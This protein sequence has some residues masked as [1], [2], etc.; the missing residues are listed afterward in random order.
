MKNIDLVI[1]A[2]GKGTRIKE[3][4]DNKPKPMAKFNNIYFLQYLLNSYGKYSF[5]KIFIL[6]GYK[7][8]IIYRN[9]HNKI[10]NLTKIKC[11][12]E[13][14][15]MGTGGALLNLKK[16]KINNFVLINGDTIFDIDVNNLVKICGN[17]NLGSIALAEN[18]KNINNF[19]LNNL[20]LKKNKLSYRRK[21][22]LMNGGIYFFKKKIL[23]MLPRKK[24]SLEDDFLP[25][26]INRKLLKGKVYNNFF[27]DIGT[28]KY[29]KISEKKL[30]NYF[31]KPAIFLDRD[32]V[33][34][35]DLG[36]VYK[37]KDFRFKKGVI[38]GLKYISKKKYLIFIVTNQAG[39]AK[40][41]YKEKDFFK[42]QSHLS[43]KL[44][45]YNIIIND[46]QYSPFHPKASI[47]K[48]RKNSNLRKPGNQM[49]KNIM[50]N[51]IIDKK[52][53]FMIGDKISDKVCANKSNIKF[54][55]A[56]NNFE[57]L[58]KKIV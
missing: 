54:Y 13:K 24:F 44:L 14:K 21:G 39:I 2:G 33:I 18:R 12:K 25:N 10:F 17:K 36:Y 43:K 38:K 53:S 49:I 29:F 6:T 7:H 52:K 56:E 40:G 1:L 5:N 4:L 34:N 3:F 46:V 30:K 22:K 20:S 47:L 55:Y 45:K 23:S 51:F 32:G 37:K 11:L 57:S 8:K 41:L 27:L 15:L 19:K 42:L 48:F 28:P 50:S 9:F 35:H 26:L 31:K 16:E 58:I